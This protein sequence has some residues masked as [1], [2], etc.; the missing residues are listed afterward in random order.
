MKKIFATILLFLASTAFADTLT[1]MQRP[2]PPPARF[3]CASTGFSANGLTVTGV[4]VQ[5]IPTNVKYQ[6]PAR[7]NHAVTWDLNGALTTD[8]VVCVSPAH[9]GIDHSGCP[10]FVSIADTNNVVVINGYPFWLAGVS[11]FG[12]EALNTQTD[13]YVWAP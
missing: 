5:T 12:A 6:Q 4:C 13:T 10:T 8:A 1:P 9:M 7:Y 3:T 2:L 11:V